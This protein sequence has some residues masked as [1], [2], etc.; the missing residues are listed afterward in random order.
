MQRLAAPCAA[1]LVLVGCLHLGPADVE[2]VPVD[3]ARKV[4]ERL[5][6]EAVERVSLR[7]IGRLRL[8][9]PDGDGRVREIVLAQ[10]PDRLRLESHGP[11]GQALGLLVTDGGEYAFFD[12]ERLESG[13]VAADLLARRLGLE[14][15]PEEAV[16]LLLA[17]PSLG[18]EIRSA[19]RR[20]TETW[21][22]GDG[23]RLVYDALGDLSRA[24]VH[25]GEGAVRWRARYAGWS[26]APGG[27]FPRELHLEFP[28]T[29]VRAELDLSRVELNP[30][31][32]RAHFRP[33]GRRP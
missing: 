3:E 9:T 1:A 15:R 31:L 8:V 10:R 33:P 5:G 4:V 2:P 19:F 11:L 6:R 22:H 18:G 17:A 25:T 30:E 16:E 26:D 29:Q 21:V 12:G 23:W 32:E 20:E 14:L 7:A 27:R 24:E 28:S 13:P